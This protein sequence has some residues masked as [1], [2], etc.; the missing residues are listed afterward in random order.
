M[1]Y[2]ILIVDDEEDI[3]KMLKD[4]FE[5][6]GF[7]IYIALNG[8]EAIKKVE[9]RPDIILLDI[10]MPKMD[11]FEVCK[12]IRNYVNV[13][14]LFLSAKIEGQDK[15]NGFMVGGDDYITKPFSLN[16]LG[17]RVHAHLRREERKSEKH[18]VRFIGDLVIQYSDRK[19]FYQNN[20]IIMTKTEFDIIELMSMNKGQIFSK[21]VIYEKLWGIDKD[22]DSSIIT[23]HIRRIRNKIGEKNNTDIIETVWGVGYR[24][25]G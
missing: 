5:M 9:A 14:I 22:G 6:Q 11:G 15:I 7:I 13:P 24:W 19:I 2:K 16:E 3:T 1:A 23:E 10:N 18:S 20:E 12:R 21:E 25:I 8:E 4:Y 17:A